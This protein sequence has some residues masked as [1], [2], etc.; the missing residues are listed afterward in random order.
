MKKGKYC[1]RITKKNKAGTAG[2]GLLKRIYKNRA[3]YLL[4]LPFMIFLFVFRY[5]PMYGIVLAF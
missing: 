1:V 4:L 3:Y 2:R 5:K